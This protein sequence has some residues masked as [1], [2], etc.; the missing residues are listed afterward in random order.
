MGETG[1]DRLSPS[2]SSARTPSVRVR[3]KI[4]LSRARVMATYKSRS[5]SA[6]PSRSS[7]RSTAR[8][9]RVG[10]STIRSRSSPLGPTPSLGWKSTGRMRSSRFSRR[11]RPHTSTTGF[12]SPLER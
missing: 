8:R 11:D 3:V 1:A 12:S 10:Y 5:S 2:L 9:A 7:C 4:S 6:I